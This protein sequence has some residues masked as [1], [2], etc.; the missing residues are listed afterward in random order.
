MRAAALVLVGEAV[1]EHV[2]VVREHGRPRDVEPEPDRPGTDLDLLPEDRE[3]GDVA[4][5][6]RGRG[7]QDAVVV[8]LG[9]HDVLALAARAL[10]QVVLEHERRDHVGARDLEPVEQRR[11]VDMLLEQR[12]RGVALA[13]RLGRQTAPRVPDRDR[14]VVGAQPTTG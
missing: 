12:E 14:G 10:E 9:K 6:Q 11:A 2:V 13:L 7:A 4:R 5:D 1:H 3:V 8:P